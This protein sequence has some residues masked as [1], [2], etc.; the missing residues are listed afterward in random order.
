MSFGEEREIESNQKP[1]QNIQNLKIPE[2]LFDNSP[3][4][5]IL[6]KE[7]N[8]QCVKESNFNFKIVLTLE[9]VKEILDLKEKRR[10]FFDVSIWLKLKDLCCKN[11]LSEK[12]LFYMKIYR[13]C[14][15][16]IIQEMDIMNYLKFIN[17]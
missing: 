17:E 6:E 5:E 14:E 8:I 10:L 16:I 2:N 12:E 1:K 3:N 13:K 11:T 15:E 4:K 9:K 7:K